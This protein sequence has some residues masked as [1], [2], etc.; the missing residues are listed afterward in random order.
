[1]PPPDAPRAIAERVLRAEAEA[2]LAVVERL[3]AAF[4]AAA[5]R[6]IGCQGNAIVSGL[7]KSGLIGRKLSATLASTGTPSHFVHPSEAMHGDLGRLGPRDLLL[8]LSFGGETDEVLALAAVARQDG[9]GV[10]S[11]TGGR[12]NHLARL[13]DAC[14]A[15]GPI[16]EA[17]SHNL[18]PTASTA[19][20]MAMGDALALAV[21]EGRRFSADEFRKRHPGGSLGRQLLPVASVIR[22]RAGENLPLIDERLTVAEVLRQASA[23]P[24][25]PRRAGAVLLVD[26]EGRLSGLFTDGD[27]RRVL[28]K[29]GAAALDQPIAE[30]MTRQ[31]RTLGAGA[32][33]RDA[34]QMMRELRVDEIPVVDDAGRPVGLVDVQDLVALRVIEG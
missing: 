14:L 18:A 21:S 11:I 7:G 1:M 24:S 4:D 27:L 23:A 32:V 6:L 30:A 25:K 31:P 5:A 9:L 22:F 15:V 2:V 33:V 26:A 20:M 34:V 28:A 29:L 3:D 17:C 12:D 16:D 19:A 8:L 13:S 10:V